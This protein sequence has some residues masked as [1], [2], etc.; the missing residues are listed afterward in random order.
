MKTFFKSIALLLLIL[1]TSCSP[2]YFNTDTFNKMKWIEGKWVSTDDGID[3]SEEWVFLP[4]IGFDGINVVSL[5]K[6][7]LF[8]EYNQIR[9]GEKR[10]IVF[11]SELGHLKEDNYKMNLVR[12]KSKSIIFKIPNGE[13]TLTYT[14]KG[15]N[16]IQITV[17][18]YPDD[19]KNTT[20]YL[21]KKIN[22]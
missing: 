2:K 10:S 5:E 19:K 3:I 22:N 13:K 9:M 15:N 16:Q 6:D 20:T 11:K 8:I 17:I 12:V 1:A 21:L 18:D 14:N 7:T 4:K